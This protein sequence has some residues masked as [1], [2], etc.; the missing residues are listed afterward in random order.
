MTAVGNAVCL[1]RTLKQA[2]GQARGLR[3]SARG[4]YEFHDLTRF[5]QSRKKTYQ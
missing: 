4:L 3:S 5:A 2:I 1:L